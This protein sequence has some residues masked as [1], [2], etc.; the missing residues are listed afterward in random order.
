MHISAVC[1]R[2][3]YNIIQVNMEGIAIVPKVWACTISGEFLYD[4]CG[5][6]RHWVNPV[7]L[8]NLGRPVVQ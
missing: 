3:A 7:G 4:K 8:K 2:S 6:D 5:G 1:A